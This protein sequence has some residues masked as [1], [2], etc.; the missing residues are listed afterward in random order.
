MSAYATARPGC[1]CPR[2]ESKDAECARCQGG[3]TVRRHGGTQ[4]AA[5][6]AP[7]VV[8]RALARPGVPLASSTRTDMERR[9]GH[10]FSRVR[11]HTGDLAARSA[12][13][14]GADLF[15]QAVVVEGANAQFTNA[16][17]ATVVH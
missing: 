6:R 14:I 5:S 4:R 15:A 12:S 3:R 17:R 7:Q 2:T 1:A 8:E 9:F 13:A 11:I 10:D 16:Q